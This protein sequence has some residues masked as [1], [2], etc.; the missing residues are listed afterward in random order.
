M[1]DADNEDLP[2]NLLDMVREY[3]NGNERAG[4]FTNAE[5][6]KIAIEA[7]SVQ[8]VHSGALIHIFDQLVFVKSITEGKLSPNIGTGH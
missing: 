7:A 1:R 6:M 3:T 5:L 8:K 2:A 4:L